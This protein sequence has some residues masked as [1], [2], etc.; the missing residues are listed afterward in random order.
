M[1]RIS[2]HPLRLARIAAKLSQQ[3]LADKA[4]VQRSAVSAIEDGRTRR[5]SDKLIAILAPALGIEESALREDIEA[6][7]AKPVTPTLRPSAQNLLA[8][9][10]YVLS[11]YYQSFAQWRRELFPTH[12]AFASALRMNPAIVR[13]YENGKL[14]TF[15][16]GLASRM[17]EAFSPFGFSAEYL[18][19]LEK[20]PRG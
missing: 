20:L 1:A 3:A 11:Q 6:W 8:I 9:P 19:E 15:P 4:G 5:P 17:L 10:P 18:V 14:A 16:D 13:N 12:T 7:L 2:D